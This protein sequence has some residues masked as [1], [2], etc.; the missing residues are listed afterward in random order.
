R[1]PASA[2]GTTTVLARVGL[3][4]AVT[5]SQAVVRVGPGARIV[6]RLPMALHDA[7]A[8]TI[9]GSVYL[10]GGANF[11]PSAAILRV[12]SGGAVRSVGRLPV[13]ASDVAAAT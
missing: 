9:G 2:V 7:A 4:H 5:S 6:G 1:A 13:A 11:S 12:A 10:F 3:D 8:A